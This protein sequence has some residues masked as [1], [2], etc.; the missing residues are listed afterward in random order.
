VACIPCTA[1]LYSQISR[2]ANI[3]TCR[4]ANPD[5]LRHQISPC[6]LHPRSGFHATSTE[7]EPSEGPSM[8]IELT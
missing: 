7:K 4:P 3:I 6:D 5:S 8:T 2:V 1:A